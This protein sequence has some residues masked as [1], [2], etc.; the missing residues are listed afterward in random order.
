LYKGKEN[1]ESCMSPAKPNRHPI[2][3]RACG[4]ALLTLLA[5]VFTGRANC[6]PVEDFVNAARIQIGKTV[7][8]DPH[9]RVLA[10]PN[11]DIPMDRGVCSDVVIRAM[12]AGLHLD[13]QKLVHE[14]MR[15]NFSKYPRRW[16]LTQ[17]DRNIDHRRVPNLRTYFE[18]SGWALELSDESGDYMAGDIVTCTVPPHRPHVM[19]VS[20][21]KNRGGIPLVIHNIGAGV[22]EEDRLFEFE[23]TGHYRL[24]VFERGGSL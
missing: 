3:R 18:R 13:L 6:D 1:Q 23:I 15:S 4:A 14:D 10:Y 17:P 11:G 2:T 21:K 12:R 5:L 7:S 9:Y 19:I 22:Q 8:Y 16:G 24:S 20:D